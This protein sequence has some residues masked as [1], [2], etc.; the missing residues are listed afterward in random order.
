MVDLLANVAIKPNDV[1]FIGISIVEVQSRPS[2]PDNID[3][4]QV[5]KDDS[6]ILKFLLLEGRYDSQE[7]DCS[8]FV[9]I[10]GR[11]ETAFGQEIL[12]LKT[13]KLPKGLVMLE[14]N[15]DNQDR[16]TYEVKDKKP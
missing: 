4:W 8:A 3:N 1:S 2:I 15:F 11:K 12:Q 9:E 14:S 5:F 16:F 13:N 10:V 7:L 6:D